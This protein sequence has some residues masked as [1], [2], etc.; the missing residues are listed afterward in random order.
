MI[1]IEGLKVSNMSKSAKGTADQ[2][3]RNVKAKSGLNR[4]ILVRAGMNYVASLSTSSFGVAVRCWQSTQP[5]QVKNVPVVVTY[6][7]LVWLSDRKL[8]PEM[9]RY[10]NVLLS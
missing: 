7:N 9:I 8:S 6:P 10:F 1:V 2:H 3:G 4:A 5:T